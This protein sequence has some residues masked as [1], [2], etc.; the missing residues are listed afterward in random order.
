MIRLL[1]LC[2]LAFCNDSFSKLSNQED[3]VNFLKNDM[4][5]AKT[6]KDSKMEYIRKSP[7]D[8]SKERGEAMTVANELSGRIKL[9]EE[10][11]KMLGGD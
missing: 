2:G 10:L 5:V 7:Y 8:R 3:I 4:E 11:L 6:V 1:C 9:E